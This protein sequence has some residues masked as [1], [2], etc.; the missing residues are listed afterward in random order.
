[1]WFVWI[2]EHT[3]IISLYLTGSVT[4]MELV[5]CLVRN[6]ILCTVQVHVSL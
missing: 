3:D 2:S 5:Y 4:L 1:M 6:E